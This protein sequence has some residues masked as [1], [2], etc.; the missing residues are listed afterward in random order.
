MT[1]ERPSSE[2]PEDPSAQSG[3][4][5]PPAAIDLSAIPK[6]L[7]LKVILGVMTILLLLV[8]NSNRHGRRSDMERRFETWLEPTEASLRAPVGKGVPSSPEPPIV[9]VLEAKEAGIRWEIS[10][11]PALREQV[12]RLLRLAKES[13]LFS[14]GSADEQRAD[15]S[16][17]IG[18]GDSQFATRFTQAEIANNLPAQNFLKLFQVYALQPPPPEKPIRPKAKNAGQL[19]QRH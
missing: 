12:L 8:L 1:L 17:S 3:A 5:R 10:S 18:R 6:K 4:V 11:T 19:P 13:N 2:S 9:L 14:I 16:L 7:L 15:L